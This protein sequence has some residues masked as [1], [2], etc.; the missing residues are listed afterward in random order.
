MKK[1][2][3]LLLVLLL[4]LFFMPNVYA[5]DLPREGVTY[6]LYYPNGEERAT[7]DYNKAAN[8]EETLI[9]S[10]VTDENGNITLCDWENEGKL[11]VVQHVPD[12]YTTNERELKIDLSKNNTGTFVNY[13]G[14]VNPTTGR[15]LLVLIGVLGVA[16]VT[17]L[18]SRKNKK[19]LMII[20]VVVGGAVLFTTVNAA[21][22]PCIT[23]K[24]GL[25]QKMAG[26]QVDIYAT[27]IEVDAAPAIKFDANGGHFFDGTTEM[28][29][30]IPNDPCTPDEFFNSLT[31]EERNYLFDNFYGAYRNG[32]YANDMDGPDTLV[33][34]TIIKVQWEANSDAKVITIK[35]NGGTYNYY[36]KKLDEIY[37]YDN[38]P[39]PYMNNNFTKENDYLIGFDETAACNNYNEYGLSIRKH[40]LQQEAV[41]KQRM[42][43]VLYACWSN[44]PDGI[45]VNGTL[46]QGTD[47]T[48]Y[49]E[50]GFYDSSNNAFRLYGKDNSVLYISNVDNEDINFSLSRMEVFDTLNDTALIAG[51]RAFN[52]E[53]QAKA[54]SGNE[55]ITS[56]KIVKN[57]K[58]VISLTANDLEEDDYYYVLNEEDRFTL[59]DYFEGLYDNGCLSNYSIA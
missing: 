57:G 10:G 13:K 25:G 22:C 28:Y 4:G 23:V 7:T 15:S 32:Y 19:S 41:G 30:R 38:N 56:I 59:L 35:G 12:G 2:L 54:G 17:I 14:L 29:Y 3:K 39:S 31:E 48:C 47:E 11:R 24:D 44:Q 36:G 26:V 33:N 37:V 46:F 34:G 5:A 52:P 16:T 1:Y 49:Y 42:P 43:S 45:Y 50:S 51:Y 40:I 53:L 58:T 18:V 21:T 27:P 55:E 20:P 8:P 6:F 9:Y